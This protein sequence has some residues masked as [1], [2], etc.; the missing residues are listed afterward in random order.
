MSFSLEITGLK[1]SLVLVK[2]IRYKWR[3]QSKS[4]LLFFKNGKV[5]LNKYLI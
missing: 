2:F 5:E 1:S 3:S 4:S